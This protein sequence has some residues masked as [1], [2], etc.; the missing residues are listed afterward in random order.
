MTPPAPPAFDVVEVREV[1]KSFARRK[2][3]SRVTAAFRTGEIVGLLGPNGAGKSTLLGIVSTLVSAT[4]GEVRYG[5]QTAREGGE[6]LRARIGVL[7][8]DLFVYGDLTV[9]ENLQFFGRLHGVADLDRRI[10]D[11][12]RYAGLEPRRD[13]RVSRLSRGLRQRLA[14]ER[15]LIHEPALVLLDEPFTGLD[16]ESTGVLVARLGALRDRGAIVIMATHDFDA[17]DGLLDRAIC[18]RQGR[19]RAVDAG[20]GSLVERY[21][22]ALAAEPDE[23][24]R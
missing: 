13:D 14:L 24:A 21:R 18:L 22:R 5:T 8:H 16:D 11:A 23:G 1:S 3:L 17:A 4:S 20:P 12:L 10:A 19:A 6:A 15:A 2:A 7:G 9:A